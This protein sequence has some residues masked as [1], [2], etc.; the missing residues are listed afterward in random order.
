[1]ETAI[2]VPRAHSKN[3]EAVQIALEKAGIE[4]IK[5]DGG[6]SG[7]RFRDRRRD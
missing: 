4:F 2:G 6:G 5:E 1:M 3:L 7:V